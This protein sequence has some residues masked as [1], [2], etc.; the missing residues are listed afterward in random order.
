MS[1]DLEKTPSTTNGHPGENQLLLALE[2]ELSPEEALQ[3]DKHLGGCW[4]CRARYHDLQ[5]G[6]LAFVEYREKRYLPAL[7]RPP[8]DFGDFPRRLRAIAAETRSPRL[9]TEV[10]RRIWMRLTSPGQF[11]WVTATAVIMVLVIVWTQVLNPPSVSANYV[12]NFAP[13]Q[14]RTKAKFAS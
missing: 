8:H 7:D 13:I 1:S 12:Y 4:S 10:W 6:I 14:V 11:A 5:R 9:L 2:R 3:I